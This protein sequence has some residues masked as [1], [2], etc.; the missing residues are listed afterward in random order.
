MTRSQALPPRRVGSGDVLR[1]GLAPPLEGDPRACPGNAACHLTGFTLVQS[2]HA[3]DPVPLHHG[4]K[5]MQC[6]PRAEEPGDS[7]EQRSIRVKDRT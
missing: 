7:G 2:A 3:L 6:A 1:G 4:D 5:D